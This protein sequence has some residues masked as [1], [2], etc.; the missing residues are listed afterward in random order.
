[1]MTVPLKIEI[2]FSLK[3]GEQDIRYKN[4][5]S[6]CWIF[7]SPLTE[8][9]RIAPSHSERDYVVRNFQVVL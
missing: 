2:S 7:L 5:F 3:I 1:M 6:K 8:R 9:N 4:R